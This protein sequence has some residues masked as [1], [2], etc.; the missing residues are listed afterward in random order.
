MIP[1]A[2]SVCS[3][4]YS[5]GSYMGL[6]KLP[7]RIWA[8]LASAKSRQMISPEVD[9]M[10]FELRNLSGM[11]CTDHATPLPST[12]LLPTAPMMPA[13]C[14]PWPLSSD[15]FPLAALPDRTVALM[16]WR[17]FRYW[18]LYW[19]VSYVPLEVPD[20]A[21]VFV[22]RLA[23]RSWCVRRI[24]VSRM[25]TMTP[26]ASVRVFIHAGTAWMSAPATP[27]PATLGLDPVLFKPH[28]LEK[29]GSLGGPPAV[30]Y[31]CLM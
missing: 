20:V 27:G 25:P 23:S 17:A 10:P 5:I 13:T 19:I 8:P 15:G 14:V 2:S 11:S 30:A 31:A 29:S 1:A 3:A 4:V 9:P 7:F 6:P 12:P 18:K 16:P 26:E 22:Q 24:P 28:W 21:P